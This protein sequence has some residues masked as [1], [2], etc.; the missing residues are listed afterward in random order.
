MIFG[1]DLSIDFFWVLFGVQFFHIRFF[2]LEVLHKL[3]TTPRRTKTR[4]MEHA[5]DQ[6]GSGLVSHSDFESFESFKLT[7]SMWKSWVCSK[8]CLGNTPS[9]QLEYSSVR[10]VCLWHL[11]MD[12]ATPV[13]PASNSRMIDTSPQ[14]WDRNDPCNAYKICCQRT[15]MV[16]GHLIQSIS[17]N[18]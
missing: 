13:W 3:K 11:E 6:P 8:K 5:T 1:W 15:H 18:G 14:T 10:T 2:W 16:D 17:K 7:W 9:T 12:R 4:D